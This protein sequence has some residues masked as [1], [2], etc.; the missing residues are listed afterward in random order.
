[1]RPAPALL[2]CL[3]ALNLAGA[4][5]AMSKEDQAEFEALRARIRKDTTETKPAPAPTPAAPPALGKTVRVQVIRSDRENVGFELVLVLDAPVPVPAIIRGSGHA[6]GEKLAYEGT[7]E[8]AAR[9]EGAYYAF[10]KS[11]AASAP[12]V[13]PPTA[14]ATEPDP[15]VSDMDEQALETAPG[16]N[17]FTLSKI[18]FAAFAVISIAIVVLKTKA[19]IEERAIKRHRKR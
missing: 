1:M 6:V 18:I 12:V 11:T 19:K 8:G 14:A 16:F 2:T 10:L 13:A 3:L 5:P 7:F 4:E 15:I 9:F 17:A